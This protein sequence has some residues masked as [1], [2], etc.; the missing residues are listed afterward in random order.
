M[1]KDYSWACHRVVNRTL[2]T[3]IPIYYVLKSRIPVNFKKK[4]TL[5]FR[6]NPPLVIESAT[7]GFMKAAFFCPFTTG[8]IQDICVFSYSPCCWLSFS[9]SF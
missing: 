6:K 9:T 7:R 2:P 1:R 8:K 3:K 5:N 4:I